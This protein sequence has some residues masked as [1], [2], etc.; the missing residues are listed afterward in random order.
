[1]ILFLYGEDTFRMKEKLE[2]II[3]NYK[4]SGSGLN[5]KF[6]DCG[7]NKNIFKILKDELRQASMFGEKKMAVLIN[8]FSE[9]ESFE[10]EKTFASVQDIIVFYQ[11]GEVKKSE[12]LFKFLEKNAKSQKFEFLSGQKLRNWIEEKF[13]NYKSKISGEA[14]NLLMDFAGDDS[15]RLN[16]EIQK[17]ALYKKDKEVE[18]KDV[19][20]LVKPK[21]ETD[22]FKTIDAIGSRD[23]KFALRLVFKHLQ[24]GESPNYILYMIN[25]Q[26]RNL[27]IVKDLIE[28]GTPSEIIAK[29][30]GLHP[31]VAKKT[32]Y[33][34]EK[35][36][37]QELKKIYLKIFQADLNIKIGK[38][39]PEAALENI[40]LSC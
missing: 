6:F 19:K 20:I 8:P 2:E 39:E 29:K 33:Q 32:F 9:S 27:L 14:E 15:W 37:M 12:P 28:R 35:F 16:N 40:I 34:A 4:K 18:A 25:Y 7:K 5:L 11:E 31:F 3:E 13:S 10:K 17:L 38:I 22:I 1:M 26:F 36:S 30:S 21:I 24:K 23:K